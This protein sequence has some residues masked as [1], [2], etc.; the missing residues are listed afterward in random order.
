MPNAERLAA[1]Q[2][3]AMVIELPMQGGDKEME[4]I[5]LST[6]SCFALVSFVMG[7]RIHTRRQQVSWLCICIKYFRPS[8]DLFPHW[9]GC[10][11]VS[12]CMIRTVTY[13]ELL[14]KMS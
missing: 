7:T 6:H 1:S 12:L 9:L 8:R 3:R 11:V 2:L 14:S 13:M 10:E 4:C 5:S